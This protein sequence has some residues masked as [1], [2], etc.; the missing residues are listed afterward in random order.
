MY[1]VSLMSRGFTHPKILKVYMGKK[2]GKNNIVSRV[3]GSYRVNWSSL[4]QS[5]GSDLHHQDALGAF[6]AP[7]PSVSIKLVTKVLL[8]LSRG[9]C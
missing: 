9:G 7:T 1:T 6:A 8:S 3:T 4:F 5:E 2:G